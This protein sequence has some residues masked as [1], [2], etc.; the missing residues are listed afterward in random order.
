MLVIFLLLYTAA[1]ALGYWS[2]RLSGVTGE[3][4]KLWGSFGSGAPCLLCIALKTARGM[5]RTLGAGEPRV[6]LHSC[7][8]FDYGA[9][10]EG[11]CQKK[12]PA[13]VACA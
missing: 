2:G 3:Q 13:E 7:R 12:G 9:N 6:G 1:A 8:C 5:L 10:T 11:A 4:I